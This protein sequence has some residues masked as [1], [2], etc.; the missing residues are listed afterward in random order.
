MSPAGP[1][2]FTHHMTPAAVLAWARALYGRAP[3]AMLLSMAGADFDP[4]PELS[5]AVRAALPDLWRQVKAYLTKG[6]S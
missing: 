5:P 3:E 2:S 4:G 6:G 1:G